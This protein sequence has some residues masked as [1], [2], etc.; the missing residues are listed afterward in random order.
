MS[1]CQAIVR[2]TSIIYMY[3]SLGRTKTK[4]LATSPADGNTACQHN[5]RQLMNDEAKA[6]SKSNASSR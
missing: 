6:A 3:A 1:K 4:R 5:V 2:Q